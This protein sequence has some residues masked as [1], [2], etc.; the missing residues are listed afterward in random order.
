M[1][2]QNVHCA[3]CDTV[4]D[5][6]VLLE[7]VQCAHCGTYN[8]ISKV[9]ADVEN[10]NYFNLFY[11]DSSLKPLALRQFFYNV[12][13]VVHDLLYGRH[14]GRF[15][16]VLGD[17]RKSIL[18]AGSCLE[19]GFGN[20]D[21]M[22]QFLKLGANMF[23]ADLSEAAVR[24]FK[25]RN[26]QYADRVSAGNVNDNRQYDVLYCNALFEHLD[27][28]NTFLVDVHRRLRDKG[29]LIMRLPV[30]MRRCDSEKVRK[31]INFWKPCHRVLYTERGLE[32]LLAKRGFKVCR[33]A[34]LDYYGYKVMSALLSRGYQSITYVR[35]P[36]FP[37]ADLT[38]MRR[39]LRILMQSLFAKTVCSD[40]IVVAEK[41]CSDNP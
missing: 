27:E 4:L 17:V 41:Y 10:N 8:Y 18:G 9:Q 26:P 6:V 21:E 22:L 25:S 32:Q 37:I 11:V 28:P 1:G 15:N 3:A 36:F 24:N 38:S 23:G 39:Y 29:V 33:S 12:F 19:I 2:K 16:H 14:I 30:V 7:Y 34:H 31:D 5:H 40:Y 35:N 13:L 20:G